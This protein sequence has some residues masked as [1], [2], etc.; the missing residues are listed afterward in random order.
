MQLFEQNLS[1]A[2]KV[3]RAVHRSLPPSFELADLEQEARIKLWDCA[4]RFDTEEGVP[5]QAFAYMAVRGAVLMSIRRRAYISATSEE[6]FDT[7]VDPRGDVESRMKAHYIQQAEDRKRQR[8]RKELIE[9][10]LPTLGRA[11]AY[12]V[13]R[14]YLE[15]VPIEELAATWGEEIEGL[16]RR[17]ARAVRHLRSAR[18]A[19]A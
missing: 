4:Q 2:D 3:A 8:R 6:L 9:D 16:K 18:R 19:K 11:D 5:F 13:Q 12:L 10:L 14:H 1:W 17:I 15:D 7:H